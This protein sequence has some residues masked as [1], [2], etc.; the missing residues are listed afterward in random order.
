MAS[1]KQ[2]DRQLLCLEAMIR[3]RRTLLD[4]RDREL[5]EQN[6]L[7][8][9]T[10]PECTGQALEARYAMAK[11]SIVR[12]QFEF[13]LRL[14]TDAEGLHDRWSSKKVF[15][16]L[17]REIA[18]LSVSRLYRNRQWERLAKLYSATLSPLEASLSNDTL[19]MTADA[20]NRVGLHDTA[21]TMIRGALK[22]SPPLGQLEDLT[23]ALG[24]TYLMS[25]QLYL[26][27]IVLDYF[28]RVRSRSE[29]LW[30]IAMVRAELLIR[31]GNA[32]PA[33]STLKA[34]EK[35]TPRGDARARL[36]L[37]RAE[38][39]YRLNQADNAARTL[40]QLLTQDWFPSIETR[41]IGVNVLS[42]CVRECRAKNLE[43]LLKSFDASGNGSL[44]SE[45]IR[46]LSK[47]RGI[48]NKPKL[49]E[50]SVWSRLDA[51]APDIRVKSQSRPKEER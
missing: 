19:M 12:D 2:T 36:M 43:R 33:L 7:D 21:A 9:V 8:V 41:G 4:N 3:L 49:E 10:R 48:K 28:R 15:D 51:V 25:N 16:D 5:L 11:L 29:K 39:E 45:R 31:Q 18:T 47:K 50:E 22:R 27:E 20:M 32:D 40:S 23:V 13:A 42:L 1:Y 17:V 34:A 14:A 30:K 26:A 35:S 6:V 38:A 37:L 46:Y 24:Q 44:V